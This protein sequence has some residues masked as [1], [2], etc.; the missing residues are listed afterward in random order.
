MQIASNTV[1]ITGGASGIGFELAR[2][3]LQ[4]GST[5]IVCGRRKDRL[6]AASKAHP[7]L[8]TMVVDLSKE[9]QRARL[10]DWA[11]SEFP[12]LNVLVN[13][14]G[15]QR[16]TRLLDE[17]RWAPTHEEL[18]INLEAPIHLTTLLLPHLV[19]QE[20]PAILNVTSGLAFAPMSSVP[21]YS[22]TKAALHSF[23]LSLRHQLADTPAQVIE[24]IPPAVNTDLGG[25][26]L[27]TFG[28][29][30]EEFVNAVVMGLREG[31][32]EIAYGF[33][34]RSS[35]ASRSELDEIFQRMNQAAS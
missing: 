35:R 17:K 32:P 25:P 6:E 8:N 27:H 12:R 28:V 29:A 10:A 5:V 34:Q 3:F 23:T 4:E 26:G 31:E 9:R 7:T 2:R 11:M 24:I 16:R 21:I 22:A 14:A 19:K 33:S 30:V 20:R 18:A 1:L 15:I 13:N